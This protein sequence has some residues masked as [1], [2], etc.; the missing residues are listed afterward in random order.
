MKYI[1]EIE[2][3]E[4]LSDDEIKKEVQSSHDYIDSFVNQVHKAEDA[5]R[6]A[7]KKLP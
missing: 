7:R 2:R 1:F 6:K 5:V 4:T 3:S